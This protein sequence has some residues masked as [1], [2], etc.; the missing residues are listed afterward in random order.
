MFGEPDKTTELMIEGSNLVNPVTVTVGPVDCAIGT[1]MITEGW[2]TFLVPPLPV[3]SYAALV[4]NGDGTTVMLPNALVIEGRS[5]PR[6]PWSS[7][8]IVG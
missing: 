5:A 6:S 8:R 7:P 3:G 1:D 4:R 2:M